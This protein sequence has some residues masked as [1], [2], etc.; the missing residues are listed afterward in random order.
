M[1]VLGIAMAIA[2]AVLLVMHIA[3]GIRCEIVTGQTPSYQW[4]YSEE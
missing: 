2:V 1:K 3:A 4:H